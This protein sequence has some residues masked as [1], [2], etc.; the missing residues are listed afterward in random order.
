MT[1]SWNWSQDTFNELHDASPHP[2]LGFIEDVLPVGKASNNAESSSL[3][4]SVS[5]VGSNPVN[6]EPEN[7]ILNPPSGHHTQPLV[8]RKLVYK[9]KTRSNGSVERYKACLV[10]KGFTQEYGIDYEETFAPVAHPTLLRSIHDLKQFLSHKFEMKDLGVLSYF[11]GLGV[12]SSDDGYLLSQTKYAS[13]LIF[14]ARLTDSKTAST[15]L[16]PNVQLTSMDGSPLANPTRYKQVV[17]S[18]IYL[19]TTQPDIAYAVHVV[20]QFM[21]TVRSTYYA[22]VLRII[23]YIKGIMFHGLHFSTHS[24]LELC[25]YSDA[26]WAGDSNDRKSTTRYCLFLGDSLI[27]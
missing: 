20:S 1:T 11:L 26:D 23:W 22:T 14:K 15:P 17:G 4:S 19:T 5:L 24:S 9:I 25:A 12:T 6:I 2:S 3:T 8:G 7:E 18:L 10:A 21:A 27:S 13:D 16:E